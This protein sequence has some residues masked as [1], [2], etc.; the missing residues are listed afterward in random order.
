MASTPL[1]SE[2]VEVE[3]WKLSVDLELG[4]DAPLMLLH[5]TKQTLMFPR[6]D[7][8]CCPSNVAFIHAI[9]STTSRCSKRCDI[10]VQ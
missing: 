3:C 4:N 1:L 7:A 5:H 2:L 8:S 10:H 6:L 9:H